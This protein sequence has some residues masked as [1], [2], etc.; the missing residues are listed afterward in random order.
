[1]A[2]CDLSPPSCYRTPSASL[3]HCTAPLHPTSNRRSP[4]QDRRER[5][6]DCHTNT[7]E[8]KEFQTSSHL[9]PEGQLST[10]V[11]PLIP[12][13]H[14]ALIGVRCTYMY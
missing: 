4:A 14:T 5:R 1:V 9:G 11:E 12:R 7:S 10:Y 2:L 13:R 3:P 6:R 8:V